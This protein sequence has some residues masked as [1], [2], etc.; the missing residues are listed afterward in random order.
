MQKSD[1]IKSLMETIRELEQTEDN[2]KR[3]EKWDCIPYTSRDQWRGLPKMDGSCLKGNV[4]VQVD[5]NNTFW[6]KYFN[7]SLK[8]YYLNGQ[9]FL[10][11]YLKA[12]IERFKLFNDDVFVTKR[13]PI[14]MASGFE[15]SMF[16]IDVNF[17]DDK[18]PWIDHKVMIE[19]PEDL[20]NMKIPDFYKS[21]LMPKA[22]EVYE[23]V[24]ENLDDDFE[25]LFP[26]WI[27]GPFGV[28]VYLRGFENL[29]MDMMDEPEFV[30]ELMRFIVESRK[31]WYDSLEKYLGRPVVKANLFNDEVNCP[32]L[33]PA[34]YEEFVLPYEKELSEYHGGL[35]YWHSCGDLTP[36]YKDIVAIPNIDMI[37]KSPWSSAAEVGKVFG[38]VSA[39]EVCLNPQKDILE[40][41]EQ[42]MR[43]L[44]TG[45]VK[46]LTE[47]QVQGYTLRA[48]NIIFY[49]TWDFSIE[50]SRMFINIAREVVDHITKA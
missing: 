2:Q 27:R 14:W 37:H 25:V 5:P 19:T 20:K 44:L 6:A 8:D 47:A 15:A 21:G 38:K 17:F 50:K 12:I 28:A 18:D 7:F 1:I 22:I 13:V 11:N 9:V 4:P 32:S 40:G 30:H 45:F 23:Y 33:S 39:I 43:E 49:N 35:H 29:L 34:L 48:N 41:S 36:L 46:D 31:T 42:Y 3:K 10:E 26:E 16:G 24:K